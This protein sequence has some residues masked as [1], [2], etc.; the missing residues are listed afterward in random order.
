MSQFT[1]TDGMEWVL[2][3]NVGTIKRVREQTGIN[4]LSLVSS[5]AAVSEV[6]QDDARLAEVFAAVVQPQLTKAGRSLDDFFSCIDG[7]VIEQG[8]EALMREIV[9]FFPEPRRTVL[10]AAMEKCMA[11]NRAKDQAGAAAALAA[12]EQMEE[13]PPVSTP[14]SCVSSLPAS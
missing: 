6:F 2:T 14:T 12:I 8:A 11:A 3:V 5:P 1:T 10:L 4:L 9:N 7:T 13:V